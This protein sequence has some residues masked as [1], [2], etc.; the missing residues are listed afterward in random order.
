MHVKSVEAQTCCRW[1]DV[2]VRKGKCQ[3]RCRPR[4]LTMVQNYE[5]RRQKP[6]SCLIVLFCILKTT[7]KYKRKGKEKEELKETKEGV[8]LSYEI[9]N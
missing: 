4:H 3:L 8:Q 5:V 6:S 7:P 9:R 1:Y 2:E